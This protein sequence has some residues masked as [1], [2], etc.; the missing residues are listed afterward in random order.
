M[1]QAGIS[2]PKAVTFTVFDKEQALEEIGKTLSYPIFVKPVRSGSSFGI[3][4]VYD[5]RDLEKAIELAFMHDTQ[6]TA[7][8][9]IEGF[10]CGCAI[11]GT[12]ELLVGRVDE[13]SLADGFF[14]Y[15]EKY[16]LRSSK[17]YMPARINSA[18]EHKIQETAKTI[19][20][21]LGCCGFARVDMFL[22]P[23]EEIVFN[24][25]NTI[26]GFTQHS[27]YPNMMKGIGLSFAEMLER[28]LNL[29][30]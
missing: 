5:S 28:I 13:I 2:V 15:T 17:I 7:E 26:P 16:T 14:D 22:T 3:S 6:V 12:N 20:R 27:R 10:E 23:E 9:C 19:Y 21:T 4:K 29:Y 11:L 25:V 1:R 18:T 24:E 8:E 30:V